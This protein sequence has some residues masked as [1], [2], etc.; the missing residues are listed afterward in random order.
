MTKET[1]TLKRKFQQ[2]EIKY[3]DAIESLQKLFG[4]SPLEAEA[5]VEEWESKK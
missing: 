1:D 5:L 4:L 3:L 2:G